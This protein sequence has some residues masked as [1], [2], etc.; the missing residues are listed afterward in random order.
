MTNALDRVVA[1]K[2]TEFGGQR[3]SNRLGFQRDWTLCLLLR[4]HV[5]QSDYLVVCDYH[6]DVLVMDNAVAPSKIDFYQVKS[7][8]TAWTIAGLLSR[9]AGKS[10]PLS[11]ILGKL[12]KHRLDFALETRSLNLVTN[13]H[14]KAKLC[15]HPPASER[16]RFVASDLTSD[17]LN[18]VKKALRSELAMGADPILDAQMIFHVT[19]LSVADHSTHARG[20]L[21]DF[22]SQRDPTRSH[23][24][25]PLYRA[26]AD[27]ILRRTEVEGSFSAVVD[28]VEAKGVTRDH[29][30]KMLVAC[31]ADAE[32][33]DPRRLERRLNDEL[34]SDGVPFGR[35]RAISDALAKYGIERFD[36]TRRDL[37]KWSSEARKVRDAQAPNHQGTLNEF[38][39]AGLASL[40]QVRGSR[41]LSD[42]YLKAI[43]AWEVLAS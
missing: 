28:L 17:E 36:T 31:L 23:P 21:T 22:L 35:R 24:T 25:V 4:L 38:L 7:A 15:S 13:L 12:Y 8:T 2:P 27:E 34:K 10:G 3:A 9:K 19:D 33:N 11:S 14:L 39:E 40:R 5:S 6:D 18:K 30:E 32:A 41:A 29:F 37:A 42:D 20:K 16:V 43:L 1:I 26:I